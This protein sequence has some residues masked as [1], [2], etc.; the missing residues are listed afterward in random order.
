MSGPLALP[1]SG[2]LSPRRWTLILTPQRARPE[3][4]GLRE[5]PLPLP[6]AHLDGNGRFSPGRDGAPLP[7]PQNGF[8]A[9]D[10]LGP[11]PRSGSEAALTNRRPASAVS[12]KTWLLRSQELLRL[13]F[14]NCLAREWASFS[15]TCYL[16]WGI[17]EGSSEK[18]TTTPK[19]GKAP[20]PC[21]PTPTPAARSNP[22][23]ASWAPTANPR[24]RPPAPPSAG[25]RAAVLT[26]SP[27]RSCLSWGS[28]QNGWSTC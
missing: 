14:S 21:P 28:S 12:E 16:L 8:S 7:C 23:E 27:R 6:A 18:E 9:G 15:T 11:P 24:A 20:G 10:F 1:L 13:G 4:R 3:A 5:K 22:E 17:S 19:T 25:P 2:S 26:S